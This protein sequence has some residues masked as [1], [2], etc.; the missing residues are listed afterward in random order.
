MTSRRA[1]Y[2]RPPAVEGKVKL[3]QR[4]V[5]RVAPRGREQARVAAGQGVDQPPDRLGPRRVFGQQLAVRHPALGVL[6]PLP[7]LHQP[8]EDPPA[9]VL[10][11]GLEAA[12]DVIGP[13]LQRAL[14]S[15]QLSVNRLRELPPLPLLPQLVKRALR[16]RR[17][18]AHLRPT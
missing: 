6:G 16:R 11:V 15:P 13:M 4:S 3:A 18:V 2:R 17:H 12:V 10:L 7:R 9:E 14:D 5:G 8:K 1:I